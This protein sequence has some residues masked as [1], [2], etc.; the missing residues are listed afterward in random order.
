M[1]LSR[2]KNIQQGLSLIELL[3]AMVIGLFLLAGIT[4]TYLQSKQSSI[5]RDE[6]S[7]LQDNGRIALELMSNTIAHAGYVAFPS[8]VITP[9]SFI[10]NTVVSNTCNVGGQNVITP[11]NFPTTS[12]KDGVSGASDSIG[13]IYLGDA[14]ISMDCAG[15]VLPVGCQIGSGNTNSASAQIYNSF[16][17]QNN[18]LQCAGSRT[19][20]LEAIAEDVENIQFLYG[21]DADGDRVVDRYINATQMGTFTDNVISVQIGVL[22]RSERQIKSVAEVIKYSLLD[23]AI[24]SPNDRYLRGVF[25]TTVKL[26]NTL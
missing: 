14:N 24:T 2:S 21:V 23:Q 11:G 4:T 3:I 15:G 17:I 5:K 26:R 22:V 1:I 13:V 25:T 19:T 8:G 16:F 7:V 9:S 12:T 6:Y 10:T 18:S 20:N